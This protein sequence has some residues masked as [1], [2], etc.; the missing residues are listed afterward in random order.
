VLDARLVH[1]HRLEAAL[2][3]GVLLDVLAVL[4]E[5]GGADAVQLAAGQHRLEQVARVHGALGLAGADGRVQ[6]VDEQDDAALRLL[7]LLEH[8]L[9]ALLELATVLGA[10]DQGAHVEGD[11]LLPLEALGDVT[12]VD[13]QGEALN[14]RGLA[15]AGLTNQYGIILGTAAEHLDDAADLLVAADDRVEL[16]LGGE[17]G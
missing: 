11:D 9:E 5:R 3:G 14:D 10:G 4:V 12:A 13:A 17:L 15:D 16:A 7:H 2:Q 1:E 8:G 6:L